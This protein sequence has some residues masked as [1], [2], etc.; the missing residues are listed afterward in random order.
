MFL[1]SCMKRKCAFHF[2]FPAV[3]AK[4]YI[5]SGQ[6]R[7]KAAEQIAQKAAADAREVPKYTQEFRARVRWEVSWVGK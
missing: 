6:H 3:S 2:L 1:I 7:F 4:Y 5:L